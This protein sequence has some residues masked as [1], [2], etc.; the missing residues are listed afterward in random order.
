MSS[1]PTQT[2]RPATD[3]EVQALRDA[4]ATHGRIADGSERHLAG[5]FALLDDALAERDAALARE[6]KLA[7][8]LRKC[9]PYASGT[10]S[11]GVSTWMDYGTALR[12]AEAALAE[13][14][15]RRAGEGT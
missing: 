1:D 11:V 2:A 5:L 4:Y 14:D 10:D 7:E 6:A 9:L 3:E 15:A 13:H 12:L 8:A